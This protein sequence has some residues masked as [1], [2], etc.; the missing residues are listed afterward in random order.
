MSKAVL[1]V[2][3]AARQFDRSETG[4]DGKAFLKVNWE[5]S[6]KALAFYSSV[7]KGLEMVVS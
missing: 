2:R 1:C 4:T 3:P 7:P 5:P 6:R